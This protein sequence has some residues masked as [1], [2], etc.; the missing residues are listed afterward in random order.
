MNRPFAAALPLLALLS[1]PLSA[2]TAPMQ[3]V[4][5]TANAAL[6]AR[7]NDTAGRLTV[8]RDELARYGDSNVSAVLRRQP[9]IAVVNGEIRMRGLGAGYTQILVNGEPVA[10]GFS[11]DSIAPALIDKIEIMRSGSAEFGTQAI[12]GTINVIL[13]KAG[14]SARRDLTLGGGAVPGRFDPQA[15][16]RVSDKRGRLAWSLGAEMSRT[17]SDYRARVRETSTDDGGSER[18]IEERNFGSTTRFALAP[19]LAWT[20]DGG[21]S[22]QWQATLDRTRPSGHGS[23]SETV[24]TGAPTEYPDNGFGIHSTAHSERSELTWT[25]KVGGA[26][27]LLVKAG[28]NRNARDN[29]YLFRGASAEASLARS[30]VSFVV[31][32]TASLSGK[33]T[34]PL[35]Q[36]HSLVLGWDAGRTTRAEARLQRD[37]SFDGAPLG[38]LDEDYQALITRTAVFAQDE[39]AVTPRLQACLGMRWEGLHTATEGR[40]LEQVRS[41]SGVLSP[42]ASLLWKV[43]GSDKDQLRMALSRS[44]KAPTSR[45]LVPRRYTTN[46]DNSEVNPDVRGNPALRPEL[47][48]G[49]DAGYERYIGKDGVVGVSGYARK[50]DQ[51]TV[52]TL[53]KENGAWI[54][55]PFNNGKASVWGIEFDTKTA[56]GERVDLHANAARN[57]SRL[58]AVPGPYN[59]LADQVAATANL[60][61]DYRHSPRHTVGM[62][63][64]LQFGGQQRQSAALSTYTGPARALD[65]Y[66]LW[67]V[68][69][70]TQLRLS[71][72]DLLASSQFS[73]RAYRDANGATERATTERG[74]TLVRLV[75]EKKL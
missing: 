47:A 59:R 9:G 37:A 54:S 10:Q 75:L 32:N 15:S 11:I 45:M 73:S 48:W 69:A 34:A 28:I 36:A 1:P 74:R 46:N 23:M 4:E 19:R 24:I 14:G 49:L 12:A 57:W 42:L 72:S 56:L 20:L 55:T 27:K 22:L 30:V 26:G 6:E 3:R 66:A 29:D 71:A 16:L 8:G 67:K 60:G 64:N 41:Q 21:D 17:G 31:D 52:Q 50:V 38:I 65:V 58:D 25:G 68:D 33:Y 62:N 7:R 5:V 63:L 13:K 70:A 18:L 53:Y 44:Y 2:Q 61:L 51:V 43:P 40:T 39:W 35:G